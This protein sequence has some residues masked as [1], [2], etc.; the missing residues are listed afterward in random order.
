MGFT[1]EVQ[2]DPA[3]IS[4]TGVSTDSTKATGFSVVGNST[5][6]Q[7]YIVSGAGSS[8]VYEDGILLKLDVELLSEGATNVNFL[9]VQINEGEPASGF[10]NGSITVTG[11]S[12]IDFQ[13]VLT[14]S[15]NAGNSS[16]L[17]IGTA[18]D[19]TTGYDAQYDRY[20]PPAP[21]SGT[22]DI[23]IRYDYEDY[24]TFFQPTTAERTEWPIRLRAQSGGIPLTVAWDPASLSGDGSFTMSAL[25]AGL[26]INMR[27]QS[28]V[29][30]NQSE[31]PDLKVI[32]AVL[33][34]VEVDYLA[35]WNLVGLPLLQDHDSYQELFQEAIPNTLYGFDG[36]YVSQN[37]LSMG[38]GYWLRLT[39]AETATFSGLAQSQVQVHLNEDWN[40]ISGYANC[41]PECAINDPESIVIA[42]TLYGFNGSYN[43]VSGVSS[44]YG[45]WIRVSEEGDITIIPSGADKSAVES[46]ETLQAQLEQSYHK[47]SVQ[48]G[49]IRQALYFGSSSLKRVHPKQ[50][51][52]PPLPPEGTFG[53]TD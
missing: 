4:I 33:E 31:V 28:S 43:A 22:Y 46:F 2:Y 18:A 47:I 17:T 41:L 42:N 27:Q 38:Y 45:Y 29:T 12:N 3:I 48:T 5:S 9:K 10:T 32:H 6:N 52:L 13:T 39:Q 51:T 49:S 21:P 14:I 50:F 35:D 7:T 16:Q 30:I 19:A 44:G 40:L 23:R 1:F 20:A 25:S 24:F 11:V 26:D 15:D 37:T 53:C 8:P 34:E 36:T